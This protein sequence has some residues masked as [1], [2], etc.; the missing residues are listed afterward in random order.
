MLCRRMSENKSQKQYPEWELDL[1]QQA[2]RIT[3][4]TR[5]QHAIAEREAKQFNIPKYINFVTE[6]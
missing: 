1:E 5:N 6:T 3:V 4:T 2:N